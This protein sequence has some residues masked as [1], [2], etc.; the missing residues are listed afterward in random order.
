MGFSSDY[1]KNLKGVEV[2]GTTISSPAKA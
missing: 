1:Q 2:W